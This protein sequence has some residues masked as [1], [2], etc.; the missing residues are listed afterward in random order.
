[1]LLQIIEPQ[2]NNNDTINA[3]NLSVLSASQQLAEKGNETIIHALVLSNNTDT[4]SLYTSDAAD[5]ATEV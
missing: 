5:D 1:M 3:V 4:L 2:T